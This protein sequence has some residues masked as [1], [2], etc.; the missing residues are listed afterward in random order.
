MRRR[1][2]AMSI[3][4]AVIIGLM[5]MTAAA[6]VPPGATA[7]TALPVSLAAYGQVQPDIDYPWI[8]YKTG[9]VSHISEIMA[10][11]FET[12]ESRAVTTGG[13]DAENPSIS[14]DWVVFSA[15]GAGWT[16]DATCDIWAYNLVTN[17]YVHVTDPLLFGSGL[18]QG[19][20]AID[21]NIVVFNEWTDSVWWTDCDI[22]AYDLSTGQT[23]MVTSRAGVQKEPEIGDGWVV[24]KDEADGSGGGSI[25]A[26]DLATAT[27]TTIALSIS[28]ATT[29]ESFS[30]AST[31]GGMV[32]YEKY[33]YTAATGSQYL[34][35]LYDLAA[36]S[37][38]VI[39]AAD[40]SS[41]SHPVI[42]DGVVTWHEYTAGQAEVFGYDI[43]LGGPATVLVPA[44][45]DPGGTWNIAAGASYAGR[46]TVDDGIVAWHDHRNEVGGSS[47]STYED[48]Y[49]MALSNDPVAVDDDYSVLPGVAT[50]IDAANGLLKNDTDPDGD[51]LKAFVDSAPMNGT[52]TVNADGSFTYTPNPGFVGTDMF[53]YESHGLWTGSFA[54]VTLTVNTPPVAVADS[55]SVVSGSTLVKAA[56]GVLANDTDANGD[57]LVAIKMS[58][59][60]HGTLMLAADG[61][62]TYT[63]AL[64]Y[65]G[66]DSFTYK[67]SDGLS[68]SNIVTVSISATPPASLV[69]RFYD[70]STGS[71]FYT[72]SAAERDMV[73]TNWWRSF[74]YEG[75]AFGANPAGQ[76][77]YRFYNKFNRSHFYTASAAERDRVIAK[78]SRIYKYEGQTFG[79]TV[80]PV[81]GSV[82]VYRFYNLRNG[83]HFYTSSEQEKATV[84]AKWSKTYKYEGLAF[85][86]LPG[87]TP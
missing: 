22:R 84:I 33:H 71:H 47:T 45:K 28:D 76:P 42:G 78:W 86:V 74:R 80:T 85:Y 29:N 66:P 50:T 72:D 4:V 48:L 13:A 63:P 41:R 27:D 34:I 56:P 32:V 67:A 44:V 46:T 8:V 43:K 81:A 3:A 77:L 87:V 31:D 39:S 68:H 37:E 83:S 52:V 61:S 16:S 5:P 21:G 73:I 1:I 26:Y 69:Y 79:V 14:G 19:N 65:S 49:Y 82:P 2:L 62:F 54:T 36:G 53:T 25:H 18:N 9:N 6:V 7:G 30:D 70:I 55:Y 10:Y 40:N 64:G 60:A 15:D 75:V 12:G 20:P 38:T 51:P 57:P 35:G 11:N 24:Y 23:F 59:P 17:S 58:N